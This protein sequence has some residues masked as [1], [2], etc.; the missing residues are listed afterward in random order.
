MGNIFV[1]GTDTGVGKTFVTAGI[2]AVMQGLGYETGVYK[3]IQTGACLENGKLVSEDLNFIKSID[4]NIKTLSKYLLKLPASP[5]L[6][7]DM[8]N[9]DIYPKE[10]VKD[11]KAFAQRCDI[12]ITEGAGGILVPIAHNYVMANLVKD[13]CLPL[14]IVARPDLGTINHTL[15]TIQA[16]KDY[17]LDI[18]GVIINNYPENTED[19]VIKTSPYTI[20]EFSGVKVLG[21]I[22]KLN[23]D[24]GKMLG[25]KTLELA[26]NNIDLQ[27]IFNMKIPKLG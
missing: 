20:E 13:M 19:L 11:Y 10:I 23:Y 27:K 5:L 3:P 14:L 15:M 21:I 4:P 16:A 8:E 7:A 2:A 9:V 24:D 25:E 26:L 17:G 1:T 18:L 6:A 22:P 12:V